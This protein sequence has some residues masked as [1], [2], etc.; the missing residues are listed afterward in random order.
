MKRLRSINSALNEQNDYIQELESRIEELSKTDEETKT[1]SPKDKI[2][3]H[4]EIEIIHKNNS[5]GSKFDNDEEIIVS[6]TNNT[7]SK[8]PKLI[9]EEV[10]Y[11][12]GEIFDFQASPDRKK[13][14]RNSKVANLYNLNPP[15]Q[16]L[17]HSSLPS[18]LQDASYFE[19]GEQKQSLLAVKKSG[20]QEKDLRYKKEDGDP[21]FGDGDVNVETDY[22]FD[23]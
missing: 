9:Q 18:S 13:K 5:S 7:S 17:L 12:G 15:K 21:S 16:T 10:E 22:D 8:K 1:I 3:N 4:D 14:G 11:N 20:T 6:T 19:I 2:I 23:N